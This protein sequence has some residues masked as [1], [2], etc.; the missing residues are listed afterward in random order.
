MTPARVDAEFYEQLGQRLA[1]WCRKTQC[2]AERLETEDMLQFFLDELLD[3]FL[4]HLE[5]NGV[6]MHESDGDTRNSDRQ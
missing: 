2:T 4:D 5:A 6:S 1:D 3:P